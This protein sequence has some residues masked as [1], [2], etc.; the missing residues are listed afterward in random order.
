MNGSHFGAWLQASFVIKEIEK[1]QPP[2]R[3]NEV[4]KRAFY[5]SNQSIVNGIWEKNR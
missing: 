5:L 3:W 2:K 1:A 4:Y